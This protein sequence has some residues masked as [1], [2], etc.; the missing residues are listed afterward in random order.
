MSIFLNRRRFLQ[1]GSLAVAAGA[2]AKL[3]GRAFAQSP[4]ELRVMVYGGDTGNAMIEA[5]VKPFEGE[6]GIK[7]NA[8]TDQID[9]S[10]IELMVTT[11]SVSVDVGALPYSEAIDLANKSVI[12]KIDYS[13]WKDSELSAVADFARD[14]HSVGAFVYAYV[15]TCSTEKYGNNVAEPKT[16]SDFWDVEKFPGARS[17]VAGQWGSEGPWEEALLADGVA[18]DALY[19]LDLARVFS[20]LDKIKPHIRK[21][22]GSGSEIQQM[23]QDKTVDLANCYDGRANLLIEQGTPIRINRKLSK[24]TWD[25]WIIPK[26]SPNASNAQK[27]IEFASRAERQA[28]FAT[29]I[30]F[31]PTNLNAYNHLPA[32]LGRKLASHPVN[33]RDSVRVNLKW[34]A[35]VGPDGVPNI[36]RLIQRWN[37][38]ILQ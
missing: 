30:A 17:L 34:Y 7:V 12:E 9:R 16:W 14:P 2:F 15:M 33:L 38:W 31:G 36:E 27:F 4:G 32:E 25:S 19:P 1:T 22:W 3:G 6:T 29:L 5:F 20:S 21:W 35:E 8:V 18:P 24:Y 26:G 37:E 13:N 11:N 28:A 23:L 10:Q